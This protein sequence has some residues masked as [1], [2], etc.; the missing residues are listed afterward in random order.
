M[1]KYTIK[2]WLILCF[3]KVKLRRFQS[4]EELEKWQQ[5]QLKRLFKTTLK[6]SPYYKLFL[7]LPFKQWTVMNKKMHM[8]N[9]NSI[10]TCNLNIDKA[11]DIAIKS[12]KDRNFKPSYNGYSVGLSS[13]TSGS[14]GLFANSELEQAEW[15]GTIFAKL[16]PLSLKK[17]RIAFFLRAN[18]NLYQT[19]DN[20]RVKFK[21]FDLLIPMSEH[22]TILKDYQPTILIAPAQVLVYLSKIKL[23]IRDQNTF[24]PS[25]IISVAEVLSEQDQN[26]IEET[27]TTKVDQVYQ[28]TEGFLAHTCEQGNLHLNEDLVY[29]EKEYIDNIQPTDAQS[30]RFVPIITDFRRQTQ[31]IIRY[32]LDDILIENTQ[33]CACGSI[34]TRID[35]I[36]GRCDD[37]LWLNNDLKE[38]VPIYPD[39]VRNSIISSDAEIE[40]YQV[41][42]YEQAKLRIKF[43]PYSDKRAHAIRTYLEELFS[44]LNVDIPSFKF[45]KYSADDFMIKK[46]R[47]IGFSKQNG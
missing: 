32:R 45:E 24:N 42:Q 6:K 36:E 43:T 16:L 3:F 11:L 27:F 14:R 30:K 5:K 12:E 29:F 26:F 2:L 9:F 31:P 38:L 37:I 21:Y 34:F 10:N 8:K 4:R 46:R 47:V 17:Q 1:R 23:L 35:K 20:R 40:D 22:L 25:M 7:H 13:G 18:N 39:F 44:R 33:P 41:V 28:C 15:A 19:L